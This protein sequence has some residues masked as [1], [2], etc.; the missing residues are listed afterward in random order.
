MKITKSLLVA[1]I[2]GLTLISVSAS[3]RVSLEEASKLDSD[4]TPFGA[5]RAGNAEGTIPAWNPDFEPPGD[6]RPGG[7]Y[8]D[9]YKDE[10]PLYTITAA[11]YK[12]YLEL[13]TPGIQKLFKIYPRTFKMHV[14]PSHR[15]G[16][17]PDFMLDETRKNAVRAELV[18]GGSGVT[19][20]FGGAP[21]PI[22]ENGSEAVWNATLSRGLLSSLVTE[23]QVLVYR[24]GSHQVGETTTLRYAP[25]FDPNLTIEEF[26]DQKM[27]RLGT[28]IETHAP[29]RDKGK[30]Y[31]VHEFINPKEQPRAAWNYSPGVRRVRR[32]PTIAYD[33]PQGLGNWRTTD[34]SYGFN[35]APDRYNWT[36][37]GKKEMLIPYNAYR[38]EN[39][40]ANAKTLLPAGHPNPEFMRYELHRVWVLRAELKKGVRNIYKTRE[41]FLDEDSW[42]PVLVDQYDNRNKLWRT[43]MLNS[44]NQYDVGGIYSRTSIYLDLVTREYFAD[45]V[46]NFNKPRKYNQK[47]KS[48]SYLVVAQFCD[49][50]PV[51]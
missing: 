3:A 43:T 41:L 17:Y 44:I 2:A 6:Y 42:L 33:S 15:D 5:E 12:Q 18:D 24:N 14:Y 8:V 26:Q 9:P 50:S 16:S 10:K 1:A 27:P 49:S 19:S 13:L 34:E 37:V 11:N 47:P 21:F 23:R 36:L 40:D 35:G 22:P 30:S 4:L 48:L 39:N 25:Y 32:A 31:V 7:R 28:L 46:T 45:G 51:C 29:N 38:F 20:T